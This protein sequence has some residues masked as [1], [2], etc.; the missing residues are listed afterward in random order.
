[1][2]LST[3]T[4]ARHTAAV[5]ADRFD[6]M[7]WREVYERSAGLRDLAHE[8]GERHEGA[9]DLLTDTFLAAYKAHPRLR[10]PTEMEPCRLVN[11]QIVTSLT[12]SP[13]F[14]AL[15][16]ETAGD[17]YAAAMAVLAQGA[18]LRRMLRDCADAQERAERAQ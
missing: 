10:R 2:S 11:H 17:P 5:V 18:A 3:A 1:M 15:H 14:A 16:R 9:T 13:E 8:L 12:E 4:A 6:L 7:T